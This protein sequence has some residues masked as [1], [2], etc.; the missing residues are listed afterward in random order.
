MRSVATPTWSATSPCGASQPGLSAAGSTR[1]HHADRHSAHIVQHMLTVFNSNLGISGGLLRR[2]PGRAVA[3]L[4]RR[5]RGRRLFIDAAPHCWSAQGVEQN[6]K[7]FDQEHFTVPRRSHRARVPPCHIASSI[8][9]AD[10]PLATLP[11]VPPLTTSSTSLGNK[12]LRLAPPPP[13]ASSHHLYRACSFS[14]SFSV[15]KYI[16][17][18]QLLSL[19]LL[20]HLQEYVHHLDVLAQFIGATN[21]THGQRVP[22]PV[23]FITSSTPPPV[24]PPPISRRRRFRPSPSRSR[25]RAGANARRAPL[26]TRPTTHRLRTGH[27]GAVTGRRTR[28][29]NLRRAVA[30]AEHGIVTTAPFAKWAAPRSSATATVNHDQAAQGRR[31]GG[32]S[33]VR[34]A[35]AAAGVGPSRLRLRSGDLAGPWDSRFTASA[36]SSS[37]PC[38]LIRPA[39]PARAHRVA[40]PGQEFSWRLSGTCPMRTAGPAPGRGP[41]RRE[42]PACGRRKSRTPRDTRCWS[43]LS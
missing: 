8:P 22:V 10:L 31:P 40:R 32:R 21:L 5:Q 42:R 18:H 12:F 15:P 20:P 26:L 28:P 16:T 17:T 25:H 11:P 30:L 24:E 43:R 14:R 2:C 38:L 7:L 1:Y 39:D 19:H 3:Q 33:P 35:L 29:S 9:A 4:A 13:R 23:T 6:P 37:S 41:R 34:P 36:I 27:I